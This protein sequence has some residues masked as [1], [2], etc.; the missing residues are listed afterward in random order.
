MSAKLRITTWF[1]VMILLLMTLVV[2]FV[3]VVDD[4]S[5][6]EN[7]T[8]ELIESVGKNAAMV[9]RIAD[10]DKDL[11]NIKTY[12]DGVYMAFY[13]SNNMMLAGTI[14]E[15]ILYNAPFKSGMICDNI[16][17]SL[18]YLACFVLGY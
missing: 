15:D 7:P 1:T 2:V 16:Y 13:N 9:A 10:D 6:T 17:I 18:F 11:D 5:L 3:F 12:D 4:A 14:P 8:D